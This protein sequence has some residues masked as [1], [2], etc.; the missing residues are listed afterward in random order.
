MQGRCMVQN[1]G[2]K[3]EPE[4]SGATPVP[5]RDAAHVGGEAE[6][7]HHG[8]GAL[9]RNWS[10]EASDMLRLRAVTWSGRRCVETT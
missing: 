1:S 10:L 2:L 9:Y 4:R 8:E 5:T 6:V 3:K 7:A